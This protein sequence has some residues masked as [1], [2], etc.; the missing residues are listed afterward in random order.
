MLIR[1]PRC[2]YKTQQLTPSQLCVGDWYYERNDLQLVN[3]KGQRLECSHWRPYRAICETRTWSK[4]LPCVVY[5]HGMSSSRVESFDALCTLLPLNVT[6]FCFDFAGSGLSDGK[7]VS[8]GYHEER[9]LKVV[10]EYLRGRDDTAN[11]AVWGRS[12]GAA[13]AVLRAAQDPSIA[14]CVLDSPYSSL[15]KVAEE[16][17]QRSAVP[18]PRFVVDHAMSTV[19]REVRARAGYDLNDVVPMTVAPKAA[20]PVCIV[21][22]NDDQLVLPHHGKDLHDSWGDDRKKIV[23]IDGGHNGVRPEWL[24]WDIGDFL[25][26]SLREAGDRLHTLPPTDSLQEREQRRRSSGMLPPTL[27]SSTASSLE[28]QLSAM[29]F[30]E[31]SSRDAGNSCSSVEMALDWLADR[32]SCG[33]KMDLRAPETR[34]NLHGEFHPVEHEV[35]PDAKHETCAPLEEVAEPKSTF[36]HLLEMG[37]PADKVFEASKW[38]HSVEAAVEYMARA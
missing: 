19:R 16:L 9:D 31:K 4:R 24:L 37:Y 38:C 34:R 20:M 14:A 17:V 12:M 26:E 30:D 36:A 2:D 1:P 23:Y 21:V 15:R 22:A 33:L 10:L 28:D 25:R 5:L 32:S 35:S 3:E 11:V 7:Y 18:L 29:G 8:L 27:L 13:T 6:V